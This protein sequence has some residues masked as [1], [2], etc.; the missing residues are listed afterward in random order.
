MSCR[1]VQ[2][3][4]LPDTPSCGRLASA[5]GRQERALGEQRVERRLAAILTADAVGC[6]RLMGANE[7]GT[8][9]ALKTYIG[10]AIVPVG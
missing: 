4:G 8:L 2:H 6:S 1:R 7:A 9:R 5:N 10:R 3:H